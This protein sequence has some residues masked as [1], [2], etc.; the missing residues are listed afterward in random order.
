MTR[1]I[2]TGFV[3]TLILS[4]ILANIALTAPAYAVVN[5]SILTLSANYSQGKV[6][7][8]GTTS[9]GVYA[10]AILIY[11]TNG[12]DL[13]RMETFGINNQSFSAEINIALTSGTYT[14]KAANYE[15]G[16][17]ASTTFTYGTTSGGGTNPGGNTGD[18]P[19]GTPDNTTGNTSD[20]D[21]YSA[22]IK[23]SDKEESSIPITVDEESNSGQANLDSQKAVEL[24]ADSGVI[25]MPSIPGIDKYQLLIPTDTL[26]I[27][28]SK[29]TLTLETKTA[30]IVIPENMLSSIPNVAGKNAAI[31]I[32]QA[33]TSR[34]TEVEKAAVGN[35]PVIQLNLTIDNELAPW[36]NPE[37]P[38]TV[39]I[40]YNPTEEE[41]QA[42][43]GI[44][45]WYLDG[46]GTL[47]CI[48]NGRYDSSTGKVTF[49]T[50]HFSTYAVGY[51]AKTFSD[52]SS[53]AWYS[54]AIS[55]I[56]ARNI[57]SGTSPD[58]F[59]PDKQLTRGE[60]IVL[61][62]RAYGIEPDANPI[63]NFSDAGNTYYTGYLSAAKRLGISSG[64]GNNLFA[65]NQIITRQ[66]MFT[67]LY[68]SL[69]SLNML[70]KGPI[71]KALSSFTD[72]SD[73]A[74]WAVDAMKLFVV[75]GTIAG[76]GGKLNPGS[77]TTRAEI[78]Q[79]IYN[80]LGK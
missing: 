61:L 56:A 42:P 65:P 80:L 46:S 1:K 25:S 60:F 37:A 7:V 15:G 73:I 63:D 31:S 75:T 30:S 13:L 49:S 11:D 33:D 38:V 36:N 20:K 55:F 68:N 22:E 44:V 16:P 23:G 51:N 26:A 19:G 9:S 53:D 54:K 21:T 71:D 17:Y 10:V 50:T 6:T 47:V 5:N 34:L 28:D 77:T 39:S 78:A 69:A 8:T 45:V 41:L 62:M 67:L 2:Q 74:P 27:E 32:G 12:T 72:V 52:V 29:G 70:P 24:F 35:R 4:I 58:K 79:V 66:E 40:P 3:F 43:E 64:I 18:T 59:S 48:T 76:S 14:V 57:T